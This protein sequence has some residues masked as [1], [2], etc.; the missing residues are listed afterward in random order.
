MYLISSL[1]LRSVSGG[2]GGGQELPMFEISNL[3]SDKAVSF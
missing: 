1:K 2:G 3:F